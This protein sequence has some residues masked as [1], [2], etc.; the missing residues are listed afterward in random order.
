MPS[1]RVS[2]FRTGLKCVS[3]LLLV[4]LVAI[5]F[6]RPA[7]NLGSAGG[8]ND[9]MAKYTVPAN[10]QTVLRQAC[11]DCHSNQTKYPWYANVQPVAWWLANHVED[12]KRHL[13]FSEF[14]SYSL[15]RAV[16]KLEQVSDE[17]E[18]RA[19]PLPSYRWG[20]PEARLTPEQVKLLMSWSE[21]LRDEIA[22]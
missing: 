17:V 19:M 11:Y 2:F 8:P 9:L 3:L 20:H 7:R 10:V 16:N 13:N 12:G 5:Q 18:Q 14:G 6:V 22:P 15:K 1:A 21:T 4:A